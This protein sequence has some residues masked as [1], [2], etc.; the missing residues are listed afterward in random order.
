MHFWPLI[1]II[2]PLINERDCVKPFFEQLRT[3]KGDFE[4]ILVDGGSSDG[5]L[6][7]VRKNVKEFSHATRLLEAGLG[8]AAQMD[9]GTEEAR[10]EILLFLHIDCLMPKESLKLIE[11]EISVNGI[12]GG[13]FKQ[14]F[15][16]PDPFLR[17]MSIFGN[18]RSQLTGTFFGDY[19]IFLR[20]DVFLRIGGYDNTPFLED[21]EL[22]RKAKRCGRLAQIDSYI[23][24]S[25]RRYLSNGK[26][27]TTLIFT[28]VCLLNFLKLRPRFFSKYMAYK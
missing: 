20:K 4:L 6:E 17:F 1:S 2:T 9:R 24:T 12:I 5:T 21:V 23:F 13:A 27:R 26:L 22:C 10:G 25:S 11:T 19:G 3:L 7:E 28:V 8:R 18:L 15:S 16:N 14:T